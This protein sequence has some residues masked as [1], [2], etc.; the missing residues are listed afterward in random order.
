LLHELGHDIS[1]LIERGQGN[2]KVL[3]LLWTEMRN[4]NSGKDGSHVFTKRAAAKQKQQELAIE[5]IS[6]SQARDSLKK[7]RRGVIF[8]NLSST[9]PGSNYWA[10]QAE[11]YIA[12]LKRVII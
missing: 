7:K 9:H 11:N 6:G 4:T 12:D 2:P 1:L 8:A 3:N 5:G 10:I